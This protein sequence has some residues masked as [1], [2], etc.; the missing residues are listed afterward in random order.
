MPSGEE[1]AWPDTPGT[2]LRRLRT[3]SGRS[4]RE[5]S[6][7]LGWSTSKLS[8]IETSKTQVSADDVG[9]LLDYYQASDSVRS[10]LA[11]LAEQP[12][13]SSRRATDAVPE[14]LDRYVSL[15]SRAERI[16]LYG[17][18]I[19]PG[20]IQT[21]EYAGAVIRSTPW[22]EDHFVQARVETRMVRQAILARERLPLKVVVDEAAL[23]RLVGGDDVMRRQMIRLQELN[24][25]AEISI[26][27]LPFSV[28]AHPAVTGPFS[29]LDFPEAA[30]RS[31][32]VFC[33]GLTGGVLRTRA[34]EVERYRA[35]FAVLEELALTKAES[36]AM[37]H[38]VRDGGRVTYS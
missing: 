17:A 38:R 28:G 5:V 25:R 20:L 9:R 4:V 37:F 27:V 29:V 13:R 19:L 14:A 22:P 8:R 11:I 24:D 3:E 7:A 18:V 34:H 10:H 15:E 2:L 30:G 23:H 16:S 32:L 33:D 1:P 35:C 36:V 31:P 21:P 26:R 12:V 6:S